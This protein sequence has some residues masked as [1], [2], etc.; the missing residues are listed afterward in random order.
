MRFPG[1]HAQ[2]VQTQFSKLPAAYAL[3]PHQVVGQ[4][5]QHTHL[6]SNPA[7]Q[8]SNP[9]LVSTTPLFSSNSH[10]STPPTS[11]PAQLAPP[12]QPPT[13]TIQQAVLQSHI[14]SQLQATQPP[15]VQPPTIP[16]T[17]QWPPP[18]PANL[19]PTP[20]GMAN[21]DTLGSPVFVPTSVIPSMV[22]FNPFSI[23][24]NAVVNLPGK[25]ALLP[26]HVLDK[27]GVASS[28]Q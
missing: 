4:P 11:V 9:T 6:Q 16:Q 19:L 20:G 15:T 27:Q 2:P 8:V 28:G 3:A 24:P 21:A 17:V 13:Q 14:L 18:R 1:T 22:N 26:V 5:P 10:F 12:T 23:T 25:P 7:V